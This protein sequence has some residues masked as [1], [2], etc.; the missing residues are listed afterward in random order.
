MHGRRRDIGAAHDELAMG[1]ID[2][3]HHAEDHRKPA[4]RQHQEREGV[5]E[6]IKCRKDVGRDVH[7]PTRSMRGATLPSRVTVIAPACR[8]AGAISRRI[9]VSAEDSRACTAPSDL[10]W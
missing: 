2:H 5:A 7:E 10:S 3:A 6:L 9:R 4:G 8:Y 1:E